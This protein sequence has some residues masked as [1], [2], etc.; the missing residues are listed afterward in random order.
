MH[1][2]QG[3][4]VYGP[5]WLD[6]GVYLEEIRKATGRRYRVCI[7]TTGEL[8]DTRSMLLCVQQYYAGTPVLGDDSPIL[9]EAWPNPSARTMES[10][11]Y[12]LLYRLDR[13][14]EARRVE[15]EQ[16]ALF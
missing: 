16:R 3:N 5:G 9:S 15:A 12:R 8:S 7:G 1:N 4:A 14:L 2:G 6:I 10:A 11:V 13:A